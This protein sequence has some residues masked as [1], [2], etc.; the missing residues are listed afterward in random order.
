MKLSYIADFNHSP[1]IKNRLFIV[2]IVN[3]K[4]NDNKPISKI[5]LFIRLLQC[6]WRDQKNIAANVGK[7]IFI[8]KNTVGPKT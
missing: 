6:L 5:N 2:Q 4:L 7:I 8:E 3:V 1:N